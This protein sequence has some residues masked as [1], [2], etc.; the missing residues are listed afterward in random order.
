MQE[1]TKKL[2]IMPKATAVWLV[3]NTGLTFK[4]IADFCGMHELEVQA[5]A[6]G[7]VAKGIMGVDPVRNTMQL[8]DEELT[9]C[10]ADPS[11]FLKIHLNPQDTKKPTKKRAGNKKYIPL[12]RRKD[13]PDAI[14][15]IVKNYPEIT[16]SKIVKLLGTTKDTVAKVRAKTHW[17]MTELKPRN[18][19]LLG[20][21]S[22]QEMDNLTGENNS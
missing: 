11:A 5:I 22:Q 3:E 1:Q 9:R 16:D 21:C 7:D 6:D 19:V 18:P 8:T 4:Q 10:C 14:L 12:A 20:L 13:R 2:P 15:W 17:N